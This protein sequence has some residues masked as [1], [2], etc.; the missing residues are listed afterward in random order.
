MATRPLQKEFA[1]EVRNADAMSP[2][3]QLTYPRLRRLI[4]NHLASLRAPTSVATGR[5][6][7]PVPPGRGPTP[8]VPPHAQ[9]HEPHRGQGSTQLRASHIINEEPGP[10]ELEGTTPL[11]AELSEF[12]DPP[13]EYDG[14][15]MAANTIDS[16]TWRKGME[17]EGQQLRK[18]GQQGNQENIPPSPATGANATPTKPVASR[19]IG[20]GIP[21]R[22]GEGPHPCFICGKSGHRWMQCTDTRRHFKGCP[23]CS[24][25]AH[26]IYRCA[27]RYLPS[28][29]PV[30]NVPQAPHLYAIRAGL[31][32]DSTEITDSLVQPSL[33]DRWGSTLV[34]KVPKDILHSL[35]PAQDPGRVGQLLF[36][37]SIDGKV[38]TAL[39]D[40]GASHSFISQEWAGQQ[41][42]T[43]HPL[44][45]S[46][47]V[48]TF[49]GSSVPVQQVLHSTCVKFIGEAHPWDFL[50]MPG[51]AAGRS[52]WIRL[53]VGRR[54]YTWI[55]GMRYCIKSQ[56]LKEGSTPELNEDR[57]TR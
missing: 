26:D 48:G 46:L 41:G 35:A 55:R 30:A 7:A 38:G 23:V 42:L 54:G 28:P 52:D 39:L 4:A 44:R 20:G 8:Y 31:W 22:Y 37:I 9:R 10:E 34:R 56:Y 36:P 2:L 27:Q 57:S 16:H 47:L 18:S 40:S 11:P 32:K 53:I 3:G 19:T 17:K 5:N 43:T 33:Q 13:R 51:S 21:P 29:Y 15:L 1:A 6:A 25:T 50:V 14:S 24:S 49:T 45:K 12:P